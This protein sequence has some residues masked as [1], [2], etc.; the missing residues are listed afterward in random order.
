MRLQL[1]TAATGA[2]RKNMTLAHVFQKQLASLTDE[3]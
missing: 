1:L 3:M 2:K